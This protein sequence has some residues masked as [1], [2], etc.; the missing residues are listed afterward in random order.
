MCIETSGGRLPPPAGAQPVA[1]TPTTPEPTAHA[2]TSKSKRFT[3]GRLSRFTSGSGDPEHAAVGLTVGRSAGFE[4]PHHVAPRRPRRQP[5]RDLV[6]RDS[7]LGP[8]AAGRGRG[9]VRLV[10]ALDD[11]GDLA[12]RLPLESR[13]ELR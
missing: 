3:S 6:V 5:G 1:P 2:E 11:D 7:R 13:R 8:F 9:V 4:P 12:A 10:R